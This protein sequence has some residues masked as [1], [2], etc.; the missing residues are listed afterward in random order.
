MEIYNNKTLH[1]NEFLKPNESKIKPEFKYIC[2]NI[3]FS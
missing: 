2:K 1:N 3:V